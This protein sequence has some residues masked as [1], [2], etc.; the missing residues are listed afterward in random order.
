M[1]CTTRNRWAFLWAALLLSLS[2]G[3]TAS[4]ANESPSGELVAR[5][6]NSIDR[7]TAPGKLLF[8][9]HCAGCHEG[10]GL[11]K[12]PNRQFLEM[13]DP[14]AIIAALTSGVMRNQAAALDT[15]GKRQV[16]EFLTGTRLAGFRPAPAPLRCAAKDAAFDRFR[17]PA[18]AGWGYDPRRFVPADVAGLDRNS[19]A[20][21]KLK[22]AFAFPNAL[23]AR[24]QPLIAMNSVFVGSQDGTIYAFDLTSGCARWTSK[25]SGEVRTGIVMEPWEAGKTPT[26]PPRLFFGDILGRVYAMDALSGNLLWQMRPDSHPAATITGTPLLHGDTLFVPVSSMETTSA[27]DPD[28]PCCSFRGSVVALDTA[29]GAVKWRHYTIPEPAT[30]HGMNSAGAAIL[31]PSGAPVWNSPTYDPKRK[32][33]YFGSGENYSSPSDGGSDAVFALDAVTGEQRWVRQVLGHDAWNTACAMGLD[34]CPAENG[35]DFDISASPLLIDLE[36]DRQ[37][38]VAGQKSGTVFGID[39]EDGHIVWQRKMGRGGLFGGVHF[40]MAA[41]GARVF[42]PIGDVP[43]GHDGKVPAGPA[44]PGIYALDAATGDLLWSAP[45]PEGTCLGHKFCDPGISSAVT[46]IPGVVFAGHLDGWLYAHDSASG[47]VLWKVDTTIAVTT[48]NGAVAQGGAMSGPG[49]AVANGKVVV[50]SG[51]GFGMHMP[52]N[53]LLVYSIDEK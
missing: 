45:S 37:I 51:Y 5:G 35:P 4:Q 9:T 30:E 22:W 19:V 20:G 18:Q 8:A 32:L 52:G 34:H 16:A 44:F 7:A 28:Y 46:A 49:V 38:I 12:A 24:S 50:N 10:T 17:P 6:A 36:G 48:R 31:A 1:N 23:R 40:G 26:S 33:I 3:A 15:V 29:T 21:L 14:R 25:V 53:A 11:E 27:A 39:P 2:A 41:E 13:M 42:V 47:A 43:L